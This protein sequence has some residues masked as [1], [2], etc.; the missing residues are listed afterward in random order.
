MATAFITHPDC[1]KHDMGAGHP[2]QPA[3]LTAIEDQLI[4]SGIAD[5]IGRAHV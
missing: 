5:Q 2:E 3:R 4:A 1:L